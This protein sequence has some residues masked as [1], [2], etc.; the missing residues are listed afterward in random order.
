MILQFENIDIERMGYRYRGPYTTSYS[1]NEN[2]V[3]YK[4]GGAYAYKNGAFTPFMLG[5]AN[6]TQVGAVVGY[7]TNVRGVRGEMLF[8]KTDGSFEFRDPYRRNVKR[9]KSFSRHL[10][11]QEG[12]PYHS[13]FYH[14]SFLME[15][16]TVR[17]IGRQYGG[18][19][20]AGG[21]ADIGRT[22]PS[23]RAY[24][25]GVKIEKI[26][27]VET[28]S[29]AIDSN[30][31]VWS[32]G[33][34]FV[35][36]D[37]VA[38]ET[39]PG[40]GVL[41]VPVNISQALGINEKVTEIYSTKDWYYGPSYAFKTESNKLWVGGNNRYGCLGIGS[42]S[43]NLVTMQL[44]QFSVDH[45]IDK[46]QFTG[47]YHAAGYYL[48]QE[49]DWYTCGEHHSCWHQ[50]GTI[51]Y[52]ELYNPW[53]SNKAVQMGG[54]E[55]DHGNTGIGG[56]QHYRFYWVVLQNGDLFYR[57]NNPTNTGSVGWGT[58]I[59]YDIPITDGPFLTNVH[60]AWLVNGA[61]AKALAI[62]NDGTLWHRGE[63]S[64]GSPTGSNTTTWNQYQYAPTNITRMNCWGGR[65]AY[66]W[67]GITSDG[68]LWATGQNNYGQR[69]SGYTG[70]SGGPEAW[71]QA[72]VLSD[73]VFV[74]YMVSNYPG[75]PGNDFTVYGLTDEGEVWAWG[76]GNYAGNQDDDNEY[77]TVPNKIIF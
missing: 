28:A 53:G 54:H 14:C 76:G 22:F 60:R 43:D 10:L 55:S 19:T 39:E 3:V 42:T 47:G 66:F 50:R 44:Q 8:M 37:D 24:P 40:S 75:Y 62:K 57:G 17:N 72:T 73:K 49:G 45:P 35:G 59:S 5:Q 63:S 52:P 2:D 64:Y 25:Q 16:G 18:A 51:T 11:N 15:D 31:E 30:G 56:D 34:D 36:V 7:D 65:N 21:T 4:D 23:L 9:V 26:H 1:Y 46:V 13:T 77:R 41:Y 48:T 70:E 71:K 29:F 27:Q 38:Y 67:I 74:D 61:Y 12:T 20:G 6:A 58:T 68:Q 32:S 69:G 33:Y